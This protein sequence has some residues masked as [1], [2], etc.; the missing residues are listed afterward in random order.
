MLPRPARAPSARAPAD[1]ERQAHRGLLTLVWTEGP[2][3]KLLEQAFL[4]RPL[5]EAGVIHPELLHLPIVADDELDRNALG[6]AGGPPCLLGEAG[7]ERA[8]PLG[9]DRLDGAAVELGLDGHVVRIVVRARRSG[10]RPEPGDPRAARR[11]PA[12]ALVQRVVEHLVL[13]LARLRQSNHR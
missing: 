6:E 11:G 8:L 4:K 3:L 12:S 7:I 10:P 13:L 2:A 9:D 1:G 5:G